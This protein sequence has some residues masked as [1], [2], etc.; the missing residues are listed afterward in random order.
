MNLF[1]AII[2]QGYY[3]TTEI[4]KQVINRK[5]LDQYKDIWAEFDPNATGYI[6][7]SNFADFMLKLGAPLGWDETF[8]KKRAK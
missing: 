8:R 7:S 1:I 5:T 6:E 3:Q 2:L 4:E